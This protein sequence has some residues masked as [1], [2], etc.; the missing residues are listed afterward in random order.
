[1]LQ[2]VVW[3]HMRLWIPVSCTELNS[4][5]RVIFALVNHVMLYY[6]I[7]C[8]CEATLLN[9]IC[10]LNP[11]SSDDTILWWFGHSCKLVYSKSHDGVTWLSNVHT[12]DVKQLCGSWEACFWHLIACWSMSKQVWRLWC[13]MSGLWWTVW[14]CRWN[15]QEDDYV[16]TTGQWYL[17]GMKEGNRCLV[18]CCCSAGYGGSV[19]ISYFC[20]ALLTLYQILPSWVG[21]TC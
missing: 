2:G 11:K 12:T 8:T 16:E 1:M 17:A 14:E 5:L 3:F 20:Q 21:G 19:C 18:K 4:H 7:C 13:C 9:S 6:S 15:R 10:S